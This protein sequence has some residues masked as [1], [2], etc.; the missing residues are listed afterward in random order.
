MK[1]SL[2]LLLGVASLVPSVA[3]AEMLAVKTESATFRATPSDKSKIVYAA[4]KFYPVEIVERK[5]GWAKVKDF[6]GETAWVAERMLGKL[7]TIVIDAPTANIRDKAA[8]DADVLFKVAHG[9]VFQVQERKGEWLKVKDSHGDGGWIRMDKTW[10]RSNENAKF[11][12]KKEEKGEIEKPAKPE[13]TAKVDHEQKILTISAEKKGDEVELICKSAVPEK[14]EKVEPIVRVV[15]KHEKKPVKPLVKPHAK[16]MVAHLDKKH[17][18]HIKKTAH[19]QK[20]PIARRHK[21]PT[22]G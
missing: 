3:S 21:K 22:T 15:D 13:E 9:E 1:F 14:I 17:D 11:E 8:T 20:K 10:G 4:D 19:A 7:D 16:P 12:A 2:L 5:A 18:K 6:E